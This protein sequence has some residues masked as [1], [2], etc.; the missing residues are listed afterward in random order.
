MQPMPTPA[1]Q[2]PP[3]AYVGLA[4]L[5][6][7]RLFVRVRRLVG[8]QR[9]RPW[10][11]WLTL[12]FFPLLVLALLMG[13]FS[14]PDRA[15]VELL[16]V[17]IGVGLAVY[18]IRLT[19]FEVLPEGLYYTPSAHIGIALSLLFM[20]RVAY[21]LVQAYSATSGLTAFPADFVRSPAT[22]LIVGVLAG[23]Y[24]AYAFGLLR[25][26]RSVRAA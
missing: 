4:A 1:Y 25:W 10:R 2:I 7:W 24:A 20:G 14:R 13:V 3:I 8:R 9:L 15:L 26:Q 5:V 18:G 6:F 16:G 19:R 11:A 12:I 23:Y 22:L 17:A 21:R